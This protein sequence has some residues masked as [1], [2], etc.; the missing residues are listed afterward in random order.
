MGPKGTKKVKK[1][2]RLAMLKAKSLYA[3]SLIENPAARPNVNALTENP[4]ELKN[5]MIAMPLEALEKMNEEF[6]ELPRQKK[7]A[8]IA[9][10]MMP[11][12]APEV[13]AM[14][15]NPAAKKAEVEQVEAQLEAV[16]SAIAVGF[17]HVYYKD[18]NYNFN[19]FFADVEKRIEELKE[20]RV[21][22]L[23]RQVAQARGA[24]DEEDL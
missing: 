12:V 10:I 15:N 9:E 19:E 24:M 7:E 8:D 21:A 22:D 14:K 2:E 13:I 18:S 6:Y 20:R 16:A 3:S 5:R 11:Y 17:A 1:P 23:Q 4:D